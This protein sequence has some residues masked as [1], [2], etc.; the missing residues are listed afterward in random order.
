MANVKHISTGY[1][2]P[3]FYLVFDYLFEAFIQQGDN[4]STIEAICSDLFYINQYWYAEEE[5]ENAGNLIYRPPPLH[6][7]WLDER[8]CRVYNQE[9]VRKR[10]HIEDWFCKRN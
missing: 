1:I 5:F 3:R 10:Y 6:D 9:L 4:N 7:V 2:S 8:G